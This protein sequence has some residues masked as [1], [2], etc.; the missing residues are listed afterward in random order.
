MNKYPCPK[1]G[2]ADGYVSSVSGIQYYDADGEPKGYECDS[3]GPT[4]TCI[5]CGKWFRRS[6]LFS[7]EYKSYLSSK[8]EEKE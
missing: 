7:A 1:C 6:R 3:E 5:R 4:V 2:S 8:K